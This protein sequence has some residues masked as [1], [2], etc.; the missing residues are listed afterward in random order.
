MTMAEQR[1]TMAEQT[2]HT[3]QYQLIQVPVKCTG[4]QHVF[5]SA[6]TPV[7][8]V[9]IFFGVD[10]EAFDLDLQAENET[11]STGECD[12]S[13]DETTSPGISLVCLSTAPLHE[14]T[15]SSITPPMKSS[16]E[17]GST[18]GET[19]DE[20]VVESGFGGAIEAHAA[21]IQ[22]QSS[23]F[24]M[25]IVMQ[26]LPKLFARHEFDFYAMHTQ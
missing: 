7:S 4:K 2:L 10:A 15:T 5:I 13:S 12:T 11:A 17:A 16:H 22:Y 26:L 21:E 6:S 24:R 3:S 20:G 25:L 1:M 18:T 19:V 14:D 8:S 23:L 9:R